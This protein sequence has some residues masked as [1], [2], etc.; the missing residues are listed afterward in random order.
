MAGAQPSA[1][2]SAK[3][4]RGRTSGC[5]ASHSSLFNSLARPEFKIRASCTW[6][7]WSQGLP[8]GSSSHIFSPSKKSTSSETAS[9]DPVELFLARVRG[10]RDVHAA[11]H[12]ERAVSALVEEVEDDAVAASRRADMLAAARAR[13]RSPCVRCDFDLREPLLQIVK[14]GAQRREFLAR[15]APFWSRRWLARA[16]GETARD[17]LGQK[18]RTLSCSRCSSRSPCLLRK[19]INPVHTPT[20][21][22]SIAAP[23]S[24]V[25]AVDAPQPSCTMRTMSPSPASTESSAS[26]G[27]AD[28]LAFGRNWLAEHH[29]RIRVTQ[30]LLR[31]DHIAEHTRENHSAPFPFQT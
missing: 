8:P 22:E 29:A 1:R 10:G 11:Q 14:A 3:R 9:L 30:V 15:P 16:S 28:L 13:S 21:A 24:P 20:I 27:R 6:P 26:I 12:V 7:Q 4:K 18:S 17:A 19:Q 25:A 31:R 2:A 5:L 23:A